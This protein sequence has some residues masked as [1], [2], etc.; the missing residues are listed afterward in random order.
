MIDSGVIKEIISLK[1]NKS[2][3]LL[4][5][6]FHYFPRFTNSKRRG[7]IQQQ[8]LR[9]LGSFDRKCLVGMTPQDKTSHT[10]SFNDEPETVKL[11]KSLPTLTTKLFEFLHATRAY[12]VLFT[13]IISLQNFYP[14]FLWKFPAQL[15]IAVIYQWLSS[16]QW[17]LKY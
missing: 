4:S 8:W 12:N 10:A 17:V 1:A 2:C 6:Q 15:L 5:K 11:L 14:F 13:T 7:V 3:K 9:L 16:F